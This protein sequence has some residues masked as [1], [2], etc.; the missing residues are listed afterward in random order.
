M[1]EPS[2]TVKVKSGAG[3][4]AFDTAR[5]QIS[6]GQ[7]YHEGEK[8]AATIDW[9]RDRF[10]KVIICVN[11]TLQRHNLRFEHGM[12]ESTAL[13]LT[14]DHG[15]AW[16]ARNMP[17]IETLKDFEIHH[18]DSWRALPEYAGQF[19][20]IQSLYENKPD[21]RD[22]IEAEVI[23]F[24]ARRTKRLGV[25]ED[26]RLPSFR[27]HAI[28]YLIE[29]TAAFFLMFKR[30]TATDVYPGSVLIPC[31][32]GQT[33]CPEIKP[34]LLGARAFTRIDFSRR[35]HDARKAV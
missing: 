5:L 18:W 25:N 31:L 35:E 3:W 22:A 14:Q 23:E 19:A 27:K 33:Y 11:D 21:V 24:W 10:K 4:R 12:P 28:D 1:T 16:V 6:V 7:A 15:M 30:N 34:G 9:V 2:Y 26:Y 32:L 13:R 20:E 29:E 17:V 8:F